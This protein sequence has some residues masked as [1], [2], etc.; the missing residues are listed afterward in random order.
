MNEEQRKEA[1]D[2]SDEWIM[3]VSKKRSGYVVTILASSR[4]CSLRPSSFGHGPAYGD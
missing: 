2:Q 3:G 4:S 1:R